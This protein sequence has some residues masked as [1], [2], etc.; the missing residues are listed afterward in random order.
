MT[1]AVQ[2]RNRWQ[3]RD[4]LYAKRKA[5]LNETD[6]RHIRERRLLEVLDVSLEERAEAYEVLWRWS[7]P[8]LRRRR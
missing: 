2:L 5:P 6:I 4:D 1:T 7:P 3:A 8:A